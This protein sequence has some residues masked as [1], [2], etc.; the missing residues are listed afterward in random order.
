MAQSVAALRLVLS[1][2]NFLYHLIGFLLID[3]LIFLSS[4][5]Y[6]SVMA[7]QVKKLQ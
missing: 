2:I 6:F 3:V 7:L 4:S 5:H 1:L